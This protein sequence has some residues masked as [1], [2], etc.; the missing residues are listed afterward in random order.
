MSSMQLQLPPLGRGTKSLL[1]AVGAL[2]IVQMIVSMAITEATY[3]ADVMPALALNRDGL[4]S[5]F[6]WQPLTYM[7]LHAMDGW[8]Q[9]LFSM[10]AIYLFASGLEMTIG[11]KRMVTGFVVIGAISG[12]AML[13]IDALETLI[14]NN[15][16]PVFMVG[17]S[18][19]IGGVMGGYC[20]FRWTEQR[21]LF[22]VTYTGKHLFLFFVGLDL[23]LMLAPG[24]NAPHVI[25]LVGTLLGYLW[26]AGT[27]N[28][29]V[30]YLKVKLWNVRRKM[31]VVNGG[32]D[33]RKYMN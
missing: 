26:F 5:G 28:P 14:F 32:K 10:V 17:A 11:T 25:S 19:A 15:P 13:G 16:V 12:L 24:D 1:I 30:A 31:R 3:V 22:S 2:F 33:D 21:Q 7:W 27:L 6:V 20:Y 18:G 23:L 29:R 4:L 8:G 9:I